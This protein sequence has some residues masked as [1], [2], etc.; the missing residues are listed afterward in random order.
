MNYD[1]LIVGGGIAGMES[2]LT[3]GDMGY[4]VLL[5]EK[6]ASIGGKMVLL[7]K[8]FPTLD[9]SSCISTPKMA[10]TSHH[11]NVTIAT[12]SEVEEI[13]RNGDGTFRVRYRRN[14]TFVDNAACT[15]CGECEIACTVSIPDEFN[16]DLVARR[17]AHIPFPQAVPK[18]AKIDLRGASPCSAA[19]PAGVKAHG[20]VSLVRSGKYEEAF[21]LHM[22]DA[23]L[24]GSLA[25]ACYAPCE[26]ACTRG[27]LEGTVSIR[28]IKRFM[29]DRYYGAH[30]E[31]EYGPPE[32]RLDKKVAV[33]GSGPAGLTAAYHLARKGY[34]VTI[35]EAAPEAGGMLRYAIPP[36][37][38]PKD[39]VDRDIKNVT[40]LGVEIRANAR[41]ESVQSLKEAGFDSV[42]L[43]VGSGEA[44]TMGF[45][46][47]DLEGIVDCMGFLR[48][49]YSGRIGDLSGKT[50]VVV[51]GGN[52]AIDPARVSLRLG[53]AKVVIMYRRSRSEM[54]AHDWEVQAALE[55]GV[56]LQILQ[57]PKRFLGKNGRLT[58]LEYLSMKLGEPDASG[59]RRP[60]PVEGSE[61]LMDAD[62][63]VLATGLRPAT[64][65]FAGAIEIRRDE[66][67]NADAETLQTSIPSVFAGG[68][69]VSGPSSIVEAIGQGKRAAFYIDRYLRGEPLDGTTFD[70]RLP[71][72]NKEAVIGRGPVSKREPIR[73]KEIAAGDR[74]KSFAE[75]EGCLSENDARASANRCLDCAGCSEC[76][77]C[78]R[79]CPANAIH[80]DMRSEERTAEVKSVILSTGFRLFD[81]HEKPQYGYG[82]YPNVINAMQMDRLLS[83]TRPFNHTLR[84]S[85]GKQPNN[86]AYVLCTGS[87]DCSAGN[88]LC[89]RV[90]C[91]YSIK[92]AQLIMGAL[93]LADVTIYYIDI[94]AFGKGYDEFYEQAR[95]MGV[96]FVKGKVARIEEADNNDL[97]LFYED[98]EG[99][100]GT[101]EV[102]H[103]LVVLSVGLMP[104]KDVLK[105]FDNGDLAADP[106]AWVKEMDEN[107]YPALTSIDG[108]FVAG[109]SS[110]ARDIPDSILHAGAAAAQAAAHV[111]RRRA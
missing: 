34:P 15:G 22:E 42:F 78:I 25:R 13:G 68:D 109:T 21:H 72:M 7:S 35:F 81:P 10:A 73:V 45:E 50:V 54:P 41:V 20:F 98:I 56:H 92:Q 48:R 90:C 60:V 76:H 102:E 59:R 5:I 77:Q 29:T 104:N 85:D 19:C 69:A 83:P 65:P 27:D 47:E 79:A 32:E 111:E 84:P 64:F 31:P 37:R 95:G 58:Q 106:Y 17:A 52:S 43:A 110:A 100:G 55:E 36:F 74:V 53:A 96:A 80:F 103:D 67:V 3:L 57:N 46:G 24:P 101:Q 71:V 97:K 49:A 105:L 62:L 1:H 75:V 51:G 12:N 23:P 44:W 70:E 86:I 63:V 38:L 18:K 91:M 89:S 16:F 107:L 14:C 6:E 87:R 108:V 61:A 93:P 8:V 4:K 94:R 28:H 99:G 33:V 88:P 2:A 26:D 66:T 9:C 11:P 40:A 30:P 39:V 82:R